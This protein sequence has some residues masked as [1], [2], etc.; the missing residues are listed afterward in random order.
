MARGTVTYA[1]AVSGSPRKK[2]NTD[3]LLHSMLDRIDGEFIK[4]TDH[5]IEPCRFCWACR[6]NGCCVIDDAMK[7]VLIPRLLDA[8]AIVVGT[9]VYFNNVTAQLKAFIDGTW[10][11]RGKLKDEIGAAV[12]I[13]RRYGIES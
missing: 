11:I 6:E 12:V 9:S 5:A 13:G 3:Y 1:D 10:S 2:S 4:L 7:T 8:D